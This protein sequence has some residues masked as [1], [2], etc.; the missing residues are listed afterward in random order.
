ME[1]LN[2]FALDF[3]WSLIQ[4]LATGLTVLWVWLT[5]RQKVNSEAIEKLRDSINEN[6]T[7]LDRRLIGVEKDM[8]R[9][10]TH[11]DLAKVHDR[12]NETNENMKNMQGNL[13]QISRTVGLIHEHLLNGGR[14]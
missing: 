5:T 14:R 1:T 3:W 10:P 2:Y 4:G 13:K 9:I 12:I 7:S 8:Q 6:V 11:S